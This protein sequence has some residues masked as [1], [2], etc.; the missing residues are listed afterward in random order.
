MGSDLRA[1]QI[2]G[3]L[4]PF[5]AVNWTELA[6]PAWVYVGWAIQVGV[7]LFVSS[8]IGKRLS[9]PAVIPAHSD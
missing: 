5:A 2:L 8:A 9:R 4:T 3:L 7:I 1:R 6:A